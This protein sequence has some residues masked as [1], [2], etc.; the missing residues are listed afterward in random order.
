[1]SGNRSIRKIRK[2]LIANRG[3]VAVR[4][5]HACRQM[6]IECVAVFS[7]ADRTSPHVLMADEAYHIGSAAS[8]D[9]YL[10][11][12]RIVDVARKSG[13][14][15]VHPGYGFLAENAAFARACR[16]V[17]ITFIGPSPEAIDAMGDKTAARAAMEIVGLPMLPGTTGAVAD[18]EEG[19]SIAREIGYPVII[20]A[21]AGGGGKGMRIVSRDS[22]FGPMMQ[23][24][25]SEAMSAFG[26]ARVFIE[27]YIREPRHIE[28][29]VLADEHGSIVHLFERECSIQR[30]YQK[31]VEEAPST[32]VSP[33]LRRTMGAAAIR[34]ARACDYVGAGT[35][36]FLLDDDGSFYFMEMNTRLQ[37]EHPITE[38]ITGLDLVV[39]QI[40]IAEGSALGYDQD[41][42]SINGHAV[43]CRIFAEDPFNDF[44]PDP[45][46]LL[47]H[48]PPGG[49][50]IRIDAGVDEGGRVDVYYD[51]MISKLIAWGPDR[52][53]ALD[54]MERALFE[55]E[56]AGVRTTI[57]FCLAVMRDAGFRAGRYSTRFIEDRF[58]GS[59]P[60]PPGKKVQAAAAV[61]AVLMS[62][63]N[64][65]SMPTAPANGPS[66][67]RWTQRR[68]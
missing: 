9:S 23:Q 45:G 31:V 7:D 44:L 60:D 29:Q 53:A 30:R 49:P 14:D 18:E 56:I 61:A 5:I 59:L 22:D 67:S 24:A 36:E 48:A 62:L 43:E 21:A 13:A 26:D 6:G 68:R 66:G 50:G 52:Q 40:R 32:A 58:A 4:I 63:E 37:V 64:G 12:D 16:D 2:I 27:R 34:A 39:E 51:P 11:A 42:L 33:D 28:I 35:V 15:A 65:K 10:R 8:S 19:I 3:E 38:E 57:P 20:K 17:G 1:M 41:D 54:R 25:Q 46:V 55:Y 47:R